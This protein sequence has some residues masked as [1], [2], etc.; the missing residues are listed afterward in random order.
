MPASIISR[1]SS[2]A[3]GDLLVFLE[4][5]P[6]VGLPAGPPSPEV[7]SLRQDVQQTQNSLE[8][9]AGGARPPDRSS[10]RD[11]ERRPQRAARRRPPPPARARRSPGGAGA[12]RLSGPRRRLGR[13][14]SRRPRAAERSPAP[15]APQEQRPIDPDLPPDHPLEPGAP[16]GRAGNSP[17][18]RIAASEAAL[19]PVKPPVVPDPR[20]QV[21]L[22]RR[23]P[24][25][26]PG[27]QQRDRRA[28]RQAGAGRPPPARRPAASPLGADGATACA[29]CWSP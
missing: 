16:R 6:D 17:L 20:Q 19:G 23:R 1:R 9:R 7:S 2:S 10:R 18:D 12:R 8:I 5:Q 4:R 26:R 29:R 27:R 11:R 15:P 28:R 21:E 22:H 3:L 14:P 13:Q 24:P 25:R